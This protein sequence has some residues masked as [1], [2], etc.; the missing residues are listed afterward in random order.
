LL[1]DGN[2][3]VSLAVPVNGGRNMVVKVKTFLIKYI[4]FSVN[5][6]ALYIDYGNANHEIASLCYPKIPLVGVEINMLTI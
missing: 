4:M 2:E 6:C 1:V 3:T 5:R